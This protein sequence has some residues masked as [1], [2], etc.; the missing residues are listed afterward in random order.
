MTRM[1]ARIAVFV[2]IAVGT[3][4]GLFAQ[5]SPTQ[6]RASTVS[7]SGIDPSGTQDVT[8]ALQAM[9]DGLPDGSTLKFASGGRYRI[10]GTLHVKNKDD[11]TIEGNGSLFFATTT[12]DRTRSQWSFEGG[13]NV[14]VRDVVVKGANPQAGIGETAYVASLEAQHAFN[15]WSTHGIELDH[16]TATDVYGDFVYIGQQAGGLATNVYIHDSTFARNGRQGITVTGGYGVRFVHNTITDTRR[17]TFDLEPNG[18]AWGAINVDIE[19]NVIGPGRLNLL[20]AGGSGPVVD[21]T[22]SHNLIHRGAPMAVGDALGGRRGPITIIG[23]VATAS[24]GS[25]AGS[26]LLR[27]SH[28][29]GLTVTGNTLPLQVGRGDLGVKATDSCQ[30]AV[31]DNTFADAVVPATVTPGPACSVPA[32]AQPSPTTAGPSA[33]PTTQATTKPA[34]TSAATT[35]TGAGAVPHVHAD[36]SATPRTTRTNRAE[37]DAAA[38][39]PTSSLLASMPQR[40]RAAG[41]ATRLWSLPALALVSIALAVLLLRSRPQLASAGA[42]SEGTRPHQPTGPVSAGAVDVLP[43][44]P[45]RCGAD[46]RSRRW[47]RRGRG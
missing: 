47:R 30:V 1:A 38:N 27:F 29:D 28:I 10:E 33:S 3:T 44:R 32:S 45:A 7:V 6:A 35:S 20:S 31:A 46:P 39:P 43:V 8:A 37:A 13:S 17:A 11:L 26:A 14:V 36:P 5:V 16:V 34:P 2:L 40:A 24:W 25:S 19:D 21:L 9:I 42:S 41:A 23:N 12:G 18:S 15:I 4:L 22:F